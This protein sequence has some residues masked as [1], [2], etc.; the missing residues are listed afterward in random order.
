MPSGTKIKG[1]KPP[2]IAKYKNWEEMQF[3]TC[4]EYFG[5]DLSNV[6]FR[7]KKNTKELIEFQFELIWQKK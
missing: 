7:D 5:I 1:K 6:I 3:D 2:K 4:T